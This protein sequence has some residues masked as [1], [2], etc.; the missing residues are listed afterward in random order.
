MA[1]A[2]AHHTVYFN[3]NN[4]KTER[5]EQTEGKSKG[6]GGHWKDPLHYVEKL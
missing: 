3:K 1:P 4:T 5:K 6:G 2:P